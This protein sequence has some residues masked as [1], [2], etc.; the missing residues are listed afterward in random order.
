MK[1]DPCEEVFLIIKDLKVHKKQILDILERQEKEMHFNF[2]RYN[3][4]EKA[5]DNIANVKKVKNLIEYLLII[6]EDNTNPK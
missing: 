2:L 1:K 4:G 5:Y 3:S 6:D